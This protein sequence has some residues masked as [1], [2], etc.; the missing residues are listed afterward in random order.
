MLL[1]TT[2]FVL[3]SNNIA[4]LRTVVNE[5]AENPLKADRQMYKVATVPNHHTVRAYSGRRYKDPHI[6]Y[7]ITRQRYVVT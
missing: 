1:I 2:R 4:T 3:H 6:L 5:Y 7:H